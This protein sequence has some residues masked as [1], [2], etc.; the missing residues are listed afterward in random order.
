MFFTKLY[1]S[2]THKKSSLHKLWYNKKVYMSIKIQL[3]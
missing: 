1:D 3:T 2:V